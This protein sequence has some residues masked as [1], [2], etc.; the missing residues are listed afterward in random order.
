MDNIFNFYKIIL[1]NGSHNYTFN[2]KLKLNHS[3]QVWADIMTRMPIDYLRPGKDPWMGV[4]RSL[5][6]V[7]EELG[8]L[9]DELNEW[10]PEKIV[11]NW[12]KSDHQVM[13]NKYHVHFPEH[14]KDQD[15]CHRKQLTR[16]ND[17]MHYIENQIRL[18]SNAIYLQICPDPPQGVAHKVPLSSEDYLD[19]ENA[20]SFGDLVMGYSHIGRHPMEIFHSQDTDVPADQVLPQNVIGPIHL[21]YFHDHKNNMLK[22]SEFYQNSGITWPYELSDPRLA[23]GSIVMGKLISVDEEEKSREEIIKIVESCYKIINWSVE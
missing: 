16:Y 1:S 14:E 13:V 12:D 23:V 4:V 18:K 7:I 17:I 3:T 20:L 10:M 8:N 11:F 19:F 15:I 9:I 21:L 5:D 2:Y 6:P 22:F